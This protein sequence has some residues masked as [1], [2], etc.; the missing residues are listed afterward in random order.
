VAEQVLDRSQVGAAFEKMCGEGMTQAVWVREDAA[1]GR[2]VETAPPGGEEDRVLGTLGELWTRFVEIARQQL[3][4]L[5]TERDDPLLA[6][7]AAD[8]ELLALEVQIP[9]VESDGFGAP[10]AG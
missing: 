10:K 6:A 1:E 4:R 9:E 3:R 5:F 7:L 2:R 8:M